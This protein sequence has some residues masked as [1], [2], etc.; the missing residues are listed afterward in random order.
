MSNRET[1][2]INYIFAGRFGDIV[3]INHA[4]YTDR[5]VGPKR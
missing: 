2:G 1:V 5:V 4:L 3:N